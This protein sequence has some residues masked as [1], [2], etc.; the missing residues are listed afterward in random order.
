M[1]RRAKGGILALALL[2][3]AAAAGGEGVRMTALDAA[4]EVERAAEFLAGGDRERAEAVFTGAKESIEA[5]LGFLESMV[6]HADLKRVREKFAAVGS[7]FADGGEDRILWELASLREILRG[8]A[9]SD[10][11]VPGNLF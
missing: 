3:L 9:E 7:R 10:L 6:D 11:P 5:A 2:F 4:E 8:I 1:K